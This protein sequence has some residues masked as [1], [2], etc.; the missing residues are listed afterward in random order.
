MLRAGIAALALPLML[1]L[2][3]GARAD[4]RREPFSVP[5]DQVK[6]RVHTVAIRPP[7]IEAPYDFPPEA[8][9]RHTA[10][11]QRELERAGLTVVPAGAYARAWIEASARLGGVYDPLT[12]VADPEK[13]K[14]AREH[15]LRELMRVHAIDAVL[16]WGYFEAPIYDLDGSPPYWVAGGEPLRIDGAKLR[17]YDAGI[18]ANRV[19]GLWAWA[20]LSDRADGELYGRA[21]EVAWSQLR[22]GARLEQRELSEVLG[23]NS[24]KRVAHLLVD[25]V[26]AFRFQPPAPAAR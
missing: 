19:V 11:L 24:D 3:S 22:L 2:G 26:R 25:L 14:L 21:T 10:V 23:A 1:V 18:G 4:L 12:G 7:R 15:T 13:W 17:V 20:T 9:A 16:D 8:T 5:A 6:A